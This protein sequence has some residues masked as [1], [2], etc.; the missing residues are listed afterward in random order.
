MKDISQLPDAH[1]R[2][3]DRPELPDPSRLEDAYLIG[4]CGTGMGSM[5]GLLQAA[6]YPVRGSDSAAWPPMSTRLA[7]L[8]IPVLEGY[9]AAHLE[10]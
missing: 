1:L 8:G 2:V 10:P 7:E 6:G 3:F 5:A 4:I 9:D